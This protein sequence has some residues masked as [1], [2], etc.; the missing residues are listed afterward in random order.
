MVVEGWKWWRR[1]GGGGGRL[2]DYEEVV[3]MVEEC[4]GVVEM[5]KCWRWGVVMEK[6]VMSVVLEW[7]DGGVV[8]EGVV[9][10][11]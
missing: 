10:E 8:K 2:E 11:M 1:V 9:W 6:V 5:K 7:C 4:G 3:R